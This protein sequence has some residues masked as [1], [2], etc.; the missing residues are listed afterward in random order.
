VFFHSTTTKKIGTV[1]TVGAINCVFVVP[2]HATVKNV[3]IFL[4]VSRKEHKFAI[5]R[6]IAIYTIFASH[7]YLSV[8]AIFHVCDCVAVAAIFTLHQSITGTVGALNY[9]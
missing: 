9:V 2:I 3:V 7:S 8:F 5:I 6:E 1:K 4:I